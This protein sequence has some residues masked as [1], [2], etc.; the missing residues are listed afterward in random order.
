MVSPQRKSALVKSKLVPRYLQLLTLLSRACAG[1]ASRAAILVCS[2]SPP[3]SRD[4]WMLNKTSSLSFT[5]GF[6]LG[7]L[8]VVL[9]IGAF[10]KFFIF[11]EAPPPPSRGLSNRT[12]HRRYSS[13]YNTTQDQKTLRE[14]PSNSNVLRPVPRILYQYPI[15]S[16]QNILQRHPYKP[17]QTWPASDA[18]FL[19]ST[20]VFGLV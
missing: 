17:R 6:L 10:I 19:P 12:T 11:G 2:Y 16:S 1:C 20:R 15:N 9:L 14:K 4:I 8:S 7:Q 5:Q 18:S 3:S 13:V